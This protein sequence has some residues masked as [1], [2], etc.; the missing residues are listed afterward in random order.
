MGTNLSWVLANTVAGSVLALVAGAGLVVAVERT[1]SLFLRPQRNGREFIEELLG[2]VRAGDVEE[3]LRLCA[4]MSTALPDV[5]LLVL[6]SR[7]APAAEL[8][9][10]ARAAIL[11]VTPRLTRH[12]GLLNTFGR[13]AAGVGLAGGL[14][15]I[16]RAL[17]DAAAA[18]PPTATGT[19]LQ[20]LAYAVE[21]L[22]AGIVVWGVLT[23]AHGWLAGRA[24][25]TVEEVHELAERLVN[26][27]SDRPD[28]RLGHR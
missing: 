22:V 25:R 5:G 21:P 24:A 8:R 1:W 4:R 13:L 3:A 16:R 23:L 15:E 28:V 9:D 27:L 20:G 2:L 19:L 10:V 26:A 11:M 7:T 18:D 14:V 17:A 12:L 6:R